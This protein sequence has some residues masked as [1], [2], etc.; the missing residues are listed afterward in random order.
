MLCDKERGNKQ[1]CVIGKRSI[2]CNICGTEGVASSLLQWAISSFFVSNLFFSFVLMKII[3]T[4][5]Y[6]ESFSFYFLLV[7][8]GEANRVAQGQFICAR[9]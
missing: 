4:A 2:H 5:F 6:I 3:Q 1:K 7:A 8:A 9:Q